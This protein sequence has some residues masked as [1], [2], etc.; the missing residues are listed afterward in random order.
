[1]VLNSVVQYFPNAAYLEKVLE[2]VLG[3]LAPGGRVLVGD[4][5]NLHLLKALRT[6]VELAE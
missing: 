4:V 5:R 2:G 1:M 3:L 6:A